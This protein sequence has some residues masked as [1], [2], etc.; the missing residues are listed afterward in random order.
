MKSCRNLFAV[1]SARCLIGVFMLVLGGVCAPTDAKAKDGAVGHPT[2]GGWLPANP[3]VSKTNRPTLKVIGNPSTLE[4]PDTFGCFENSEIHALLRLPRKITG[5]HT[6][7]ADWRGPDGTRERL[8]QLDLNLQA[9]GQD[10]FL[11]WLDIRIERP[12]PLAVISPANDLLKTKFNGKW[13]VSASLDE[14]RNLASAE[15]TVACH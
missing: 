15:F 11:F 8:T 7:R 9:P 5:K 12:A 13:R 14:E 10:Y 2:T 1:A 4:T 3:L 6:L